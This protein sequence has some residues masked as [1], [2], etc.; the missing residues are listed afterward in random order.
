MR[1]PEVPP[2]EQPPQVSGVVAAERAF[3]WQPYSRESFQRAE[4]EGRYVLLH[5]S[6]AWC[7]WCHVME[8][9]TYRDP[10]VARLLRERFVA[11][12]V[13]VDARPDI[14]E[15]YGAWG[16]PATIL[17][18][19]EGREVGKFRGY[20]ASSELLP[21]LQTVEDQSAPEGG[22][23]ARGEPGPGSAPVLAL[24]WIMRRALRDMEWFWDEQGGS[25]GTRQRAPLGD[26]A[27]VELR[28]GARGDADALARG[29]LALEKQAA[30][31]DPVW[32]GI[33][34]Y[35]T[36]STWDAP[37]YEKLMTFQA[38]NLEAYAEAYALLGEGF[39]LQ[40]ARA[41][42]GYVER[43][44]TSPEGTFYVSQDADVGAHDPEQEFV[45]GRDYYSKSGPEREKLGFPR[46]D[47]HVYAY[48]NGLMIAAL[49]RLHEAVNGE[50]STPP[51]A[52]AQRALDRVLVTHVQDGSVRH[53]AESDSPVRYLVDAAG[54]G[55]GAC[56]VAEATGDRE[57]RDA[58]VAIAARMD[59]ELLDERTGAYVAHT[60][61]PDA[62]GVFAERRHPFRHN[63]LAARFLAC[64]WRVTG[65]TSYRDAAQRT[66][67][68][69]ATPLALDAQGRMLGSFLLALDEA[70]IPLPGG[71]KDSTR[72]DEA[73][74]EAPSEE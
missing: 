31:V 28:R 46:V 64:L 23:A 66:L 37:H 7:H 48:E 2:S 70:G 33:Y 69:V 55:R 50:G 24:P 18:D 9:T 32:G 56:R 30:L 74:K 4:K 59:E 14:A 39:F 1:E 34:Q 17:F 41:I 10:A 3:D 45:A 49:V 35:S 29:K 42:D 44:L 47:E 16:W 57:Y 63:V 67:A 40:Q 54:L 71:P 15:R 43:F 26:N 8:E 65:K 22:D 11:I 61:D 27:E 38:L 20:I 13:D 25:W 53:D 51:L 12:K 60:E 62:W 72:G 36:G 52:K 19:P 21:I 58:A 5:G 68:A 6:A 73:R